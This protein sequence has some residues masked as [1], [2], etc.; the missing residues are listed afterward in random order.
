MPPGA[1]LGALAARDTAGAETHGLARQGRHGTE[2]TGWGPKTFP[3]APDATRGECLRVVSVPS[4]VV[5]LI[6]GGGGANLDRMRRLY[7]GIHTRV[8]DRDEP[9]T[10]PLAETARRQRIAFTG[11]HEA[12][13]AAVADVRVILNVQAAAVGLPLELVDC[14]APPPESYPA[15]APPLGVSCA[16]D[17]ARLPGQRLVDALYDFLVARG[18]DGI[19][20]TYMTEFHDACPGHRAKKCKGS[21]I[22]RVITQFGG[23]K[24]KWAYEARGNGRVVVV[25][26]EKAGD[27]F[28]APHA[29]SG[30]YGPAAPVPLAANPNRAPVSGAEGYGGLPGIAGRL[31]PP[32]APPPP[33]KRNVVLL[34]L[35]HTLV[36]VLPRDRMPPEAAELSEGIAPMTVV[37]GYHDLAGDLS[38]AVRKGASDLIWMLRNAGDV[39]LRIVTMNLEGVGVVHAIADALN[40]AADAD[41]TGVAAT[42]ARLRALSLIWRDLPVIVIGGEARKRYQATRAPAKFLPADLALSLLSDDR[43]AIVDDTQDCWAHELQGHVVKILPYT[44]LADHSELERADEFACL[45]RLTRDF[46]AVLNARG[47][48]WPL[49]GYRTFAQEVAHRQAQDRAM[50][51]NQSPNRRWMGTGGRR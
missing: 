5:G 7:G 50:T 37:A 35:D 27:D 17:D 36:H 18:R 2:T 46:S 26:N 10:Q 16:V 32:A 34:D 11:V 12:V 22:K 30:A 21:G 3:R 1:A 45:A 28:T 31:R 42:A 51:L 33:P 41:T 15:V 47:R 48:V 43:L 8:A 23:A 40:Q 14:A 25:G 24:L 38:V 29:K 6:I 49:P 20:P 44:V 39:D 4:S 19:D 13:D 9:W